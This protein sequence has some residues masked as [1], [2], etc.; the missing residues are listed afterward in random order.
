V[1]SGFRMLSVAALAGGLAV[2]GLGVATLNAQP[3]PASGPNEYLRLVVEPEIET[4]GDLQQDCRLTRAARARTGLSLPAMPRGG[5]LFGIVDVGWGRDADQVSVPLKLMEL[6]FQPPTGIGGAPRCRT[7]ADTRTFRSP[8]F[9][10]ATHQDEPFTVSFRTAVTNRVDTATVGRWTQFLT[11]MTAME[12]PLA[13]VDLTGFNVDG[14]VRDLI[15]EGEA[16]S[17]TIT[18][19]YSHA[20]NSQPDVVTLISYETRSGTITARARIRVEAVASAFNGH[21]TRASGQY[22][23]FSGIEPVMLAQSTI[24]GRDLRT[25]VNQRADR[26]WDRFAAAGSPVDLDRIC[27]EAQDRLTAGGLSVA[28]A[29]AV[30]WI[31]VNTHPNPVVAEQVRA[32]DCLARREAVL[33]RFGLA[34]PQLLD[35]AGDAIL[36]HLGGEDRL[37]AFFGLDPA[38]D[39]SRTAY[40]RLSRDLFSE[41]SGVSLRDPDRSVLRRAS[42]PLGGFDLWD[43]LLTRPLRIGC[44][45]PV[46]GDGQGR[47]SGFHA[48]GVDAGGVEVLI[49][50]GFARRPAGAPPRLDSLS[51]NEGRD[52]G[53]RL[54][55]EAWSGQGACDGGLRPVSLFGPPPSPPSPAVPEGSGPDGLGPVIAGDVAPTPEVAPSTEPATPDSA[56]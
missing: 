2:S 12:G 53:L 5:Q 29:A 50:G 34:V 55:G 52:I 26:A 25:L 41:S 45:T 54:I 17:S 15:G 51:F 10:M 23:D 20:A 16:R 6:E 33:R 14:A 35:P 32:I 48:I 7:S 3:A 21:A 4:P 8:L 11:R 46:V 47:R 31:M 56:A 40:T 38:D 9:L 13:L 19:N 1:T 36:A 30:S 28:D 24:A 44:L 43:L 18:R 27:R 22:P 37:S 42:F 39:A 49:T